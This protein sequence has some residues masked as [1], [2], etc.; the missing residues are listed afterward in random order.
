MSKLLQKEQFSTHLK[1]NKK[2]EQ[3]TPWNYDLLLNDLSLKR[4]IQ[5]DIWNCRI[6]SMLENY[7]SDV[8]KDKK[9]INFRKSGKI[10]YSSSYLLKNKTKLIINDS[11][12]AQEDMEEI[13]QSIFKSAPEED[14]EF[15][16]DLYESDEYTDTGELKKRINRINLN[17]LSLNE[18]NQ[19][20]TNREIAL[21]SPKKLAY[22]KIGLNDLASALTD[23]MKLKERTKVVRK[24][25]QRDINDMDFLPKNLIKNQIEKRES[26]TVRIEKFYN[27]LTKVYEN[28]PISFLDLIEKPSIQ[29]LIDTIL[30]LLHLC[31]KKKIHIWQDVNQIRTEKSD[32]SENNNGY[33]LN[34]IYISPIVK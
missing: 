32:E 5:R 10:L 6:D 27:K 30:Y 8:N 1:L 2:Q 4:I 9:D 28:E 22:K 15:D 31:T 34:N 3:S 18:L 14:F 20:I 23:V 26:L 11:L 12:S 19:K 17:K 21:K 13:E 25:V 7:I 33:S 16:E 24:I 29:E